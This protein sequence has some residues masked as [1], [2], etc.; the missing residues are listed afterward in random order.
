MSSDSEW[1]SKA[2]VNTQAVLRR[3]QHYQALHTPRERWQVHTIFTDEMS[4]LE[5]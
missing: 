5:G 4:P 1:I 3:A 2:R